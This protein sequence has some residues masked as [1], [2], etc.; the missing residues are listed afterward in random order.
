MLDAIEI[1]NNKIHGYGAVN[2][3]RNLSQC[4]LHLAERAVDEHDLNKVE[5][6][7]PRDSFPRDSN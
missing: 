6:V 5:G 2:F 3:G 1:E 4:Y 7:R